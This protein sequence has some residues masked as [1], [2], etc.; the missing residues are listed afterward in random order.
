MKIVLAF[1]SFKGCLSA[2]EACVAA[3]EGI[4]LCLPSANVVSLPMSDGGEGLV[5]CI[6]RIMPLTPVT[7]TAH[8]PLMDPITASYGLSADG[9]TAYMEMAATSGLTLVEES[10]R[11]PMI[12]TTFGVGEML[13]HAQQKGCEHVVMGIGGSATCDAGRGMLEALEGHLPL[14]MDITVACDVTNPLYGANGASYVFAPQ[15]G[16]TAEQVEILDQ[17]LRDF[18]RTTEAKGLATTELAHHP[19]AG[20]AGGL[21][22]GLMAYLGAKLCSGIDILM[23]IMRFDDIIADAD[24]IVT[25]EGKSDAQTLMG[26]VP[27]GVL[28][29]AKKH[30][31]PVALISGAI[32][33]AASL[34]AAG[35][36]LVKSIN[37][38]D[39]RPLNILMQKEVAYQ[40]LKKMAST[41]CLLSASQ[42]GKE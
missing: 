27:Y 22:Y 33:D 18:A 3:T 39:N 14:G 13:L 12:T 23:Q 11:N 7:F 34:T 16:A 20:A 15:K 9:K 38:N 21:G 35:F 8:N 29:R 10:R 2:E 41:Q 6:K 37:E 4:R 1:D 32:D 40:N 25:G 26:K 30:H 5:E 19:G 28:Q 42:G 31:V 17:Q 36:S 24:L